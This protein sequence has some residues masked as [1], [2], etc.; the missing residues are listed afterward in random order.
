MLFLI[1]WSKIVG[2]D[3]SPVTD[4]DAG[5]TWYRDVL[6][7]ERVPQLDYDHPDGG[8]HATV[9]VHPGSGTGAQRAHRFSLTRTSASQPAVARP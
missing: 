8:G 3:V 6:G 7:F 2:F 1:A 9:V 5:L 4:V